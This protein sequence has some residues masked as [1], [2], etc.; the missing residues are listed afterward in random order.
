VDS[1]RRKPAPPAGTQSLSR[2]LEL[3]IALGQANGSASV[4]ELSAHLDLHPSTTS[5]LLGALEAYD[6]V[7]QDARTQRF[8]LGARCLQLGQVFVSQVEVADVAEP[9][10]REVT[11]DTGLQSHLA[12]LRSGRV[13]HVRHVSPEGH[14]PTRPVAERYAVGEVYTE[15]LGKALLAFQPDNVVADILDAITFQRHTATTITTRGRLLDEIRRVRRCGYAIDNGELVEYVRC[16]AVPIWDHA[17]EVVAAMSV[18]GSDRQVTPQRIEALAAALR[19]A[20]DAVS[21][22]LGATRSRPGAH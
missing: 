16:V 15:A 6:F 10:M 19:K 9:Y 22:R 3:L 8:Q 20:A 21:R 13:V 17:E 11:T 18:S 1:A 5:R 12:V 14:V 4:A 2:A 7:I